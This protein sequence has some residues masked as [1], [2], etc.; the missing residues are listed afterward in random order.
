MDATTK[1]NGV[2]SEI[3]NDNT[4][5]LS[6]NTAEGITKTITQTQQEII[7]EPDNV[8]NENNVSTKVLWNKLK[9]IKYK[10]HNNVVCNNK[11]SCFWYTC[12]FDN[13]PIYIQNVK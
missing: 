5:S 4:N 7:T 3:I 11:S 2:T 10:L 1:N 8:K 13:P 12:S 9:E 6:I